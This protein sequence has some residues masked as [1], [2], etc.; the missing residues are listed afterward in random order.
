MKKL[1]T[2]L[3]P[4]T[5]MG[6]AG[7]TPAQAAIVAGW[8]Q[9]T[10]DGASYPKAADTV[11][12]NITSTGLNTAGIRHLSSQFVGFNFALG[13]LNTAS[14]GSTGSW[15]TGSTV[16]T[17]QYLEFA[18]QPG[19]GFQVDFTN[20]Q[21]NAKRDETG[22]DL[23]LRSSVDG[24]TNNLGTQVSLTTSFNTYSFDL[25]SLAPQTGP[26]QFRLYGLNA[27]SFSVFFF[28]EN[29]ANV[30]GGGFVALNG[31]ITPTGGGA[32]STPEPSGIV[33][34]IAVGALGAASLRRRG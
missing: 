33:S 3:T 25:S 15:N 28:G 19:A 6:L 20:L 22:L 2:M 10:T 34:L 18:V 8:N 13:G 27:D 29:S 21:L 4:L 30:A 16:N 9:F 1:L 23:V 5:L 31:D 12:T 11:G 26:V 24:F 32:V 17:S 14:D 7:V